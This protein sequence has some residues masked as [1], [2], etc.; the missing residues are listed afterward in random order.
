ML[1]EDGDTERGVDPLFVHAIEDEEDCS[2][3]DSCGSEYQD[4]AS[5]PSV[6]DINKNEVAKDQ[7]HVSQGGSHSLLCISSSGE[8]ASTLISDPDAVSETGG[9]SVTE[10]DI[11]E[12]VN[13]ENIQIASSLLSTSTSEA[14]PQIEDSVCIPPN[15]DWV[16]L[17]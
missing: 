1:Y 5:E 2:S 14:Q 8:S 11:Q 7:L 13:L 16:V 10:T 6:D 9:P 4:C 12:E 15:G 3:E 17:K